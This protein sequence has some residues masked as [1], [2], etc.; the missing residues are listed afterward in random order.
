[1]DNET[2]K[3]NLLNEIWKLQAGVY[4]KAD[5]ERFDPAITGCGVSVLAIFERLPNVEPDAMAIAAK[6]LVEEGSLSANEENDYVSFRAN[7]N[8]TQRAERL[9]TEKLSR[10]EVKMVYNIV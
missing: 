1:M 6:E 10:Y 4:S 8:V 7:E 5:I 9:L 3:N 2:L